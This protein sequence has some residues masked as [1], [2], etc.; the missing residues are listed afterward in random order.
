MYVAFLNP[1]IARVTKNTLK[2]ATSLHS[3]FAS[4]HKMEQQITKTSYFDGAKAS[5][6][7]Q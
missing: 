4:V 3:I 7:K 6:Q 1:L 5:L 2:P